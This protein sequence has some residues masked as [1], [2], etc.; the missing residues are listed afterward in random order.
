M[1][2]IKTPKISENCDTKNSIVKQKTLAPLEPQ[3]LD[4]VNRI[5]SCFHAIITGGTDVEYK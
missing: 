1:T 2:Q 3:K 5:L 4:N